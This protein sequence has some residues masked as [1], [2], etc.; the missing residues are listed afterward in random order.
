MHRRLEASADRHAIEGEETHGDAPRL[1]DGIR[2]CV[3]VFIVVRLALS[4]LGVV[5]VQD[6]DVP[7]DGVGA[8][9]QG[10]EQP[11]TRGWH[12]AVDGTVRWDAYW[13]LA[14]AAHGY[15]GSGQDAAFFPGYPASIS[16]V[17]RSLPV[18]L[19]DSAILVSN[20]AFLAALVVLYALTTY[21]FTEEVARRT[22]LFTA[23]FP[24]AFFFF[25]PYSESSFMLLTVLVF[26][27]ARRDRWLIAA[28]AAAAAASVR[29]IGVVLIPCLLIEALTVRRSATTRGVRVLASFAPVLPLALYSLWWFA[30]NGDLL[31]PFHAQS[32]W[33]RSLAF[34][35]VTLADGLALGIKGI[36][37]PHGIYWTAD[38]VIATAAVVP[39][40]L[41]W[42]R[43]AQ[44]YVTYAVLSLLIP[45][46][47]PLSARPLL[48]VP[49]FVI[50]VFPLFWAMALLLE[51]Q[52][53]RRLA[54]GLSALGFA[55]ASLAFMNWGYLF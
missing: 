3:G 51:S 52:L 32:G 9:G 11:A 34:P 14:V 42:R 38:L 13:Y 55:V 4:V 31:A 27:W 50:V 43:I 35:L 12:N 29:S 17:D 39:F 22:V 10:S 28:V 8:T 30:R 20:G 33:M 41:R 15:P 48:S 54:L 44:P 49:R 40:C 46:T 18:T 25:A 37:H 45:L 16:A 19:E 26:W 2:F 36:G 53:A 7:Q 47:Y 6:R 23:L 1:R 5:G 24:T 21:E